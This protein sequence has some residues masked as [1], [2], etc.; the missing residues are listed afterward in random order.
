MLPRLHGLLLHT[1]RAQTRLYPVHLQYT[2]QYVAERFF[3]ISDEFGFNRLTPCSVS[4][5]SR[6]LLTSATSEVFASGPGL[7]SVVRVLYE[8]QE[9]W[10]M[11]L[12]APA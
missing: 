6:V 8:I 12:P 1:E 2:L 11:C 5:S 10:L 3:G 7:G 9:L 4:R